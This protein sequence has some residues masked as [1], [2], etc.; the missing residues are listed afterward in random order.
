MK[1]TNKTNIS[2]IISLIIL[3][4]SCGLY[5]YLY[6]SF[7]R[8]T[9]EVRSM[10]V[11]NAKN[12]AALSELHRVEQNLKNTLGTKDQLAS[13]FVTEESVVDF[14]QLLESIMKRGG[15]DGSVDSVTESAGGTLNVTL[16]LSGSWNSLLQFTAEVENLPYNSTIDSLRLNY[17]KASGDTSAAKPG[18][19]PGWNENMV[20]HVLMR[21]NNNEK[22]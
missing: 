6:L 5:T 10:H 3:L 14:I 18:Q 4:L 20:L 1:Y 12:E 22:L 8:T 15:I 16:S 9:E 21:Q 7:N 2:L 19:K 17:V 11:D 13:L